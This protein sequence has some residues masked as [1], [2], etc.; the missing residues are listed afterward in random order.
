MAW[1]SPG[2]CTWCGTHG[3][4]GLPQGPSRRIR[5]QLAL[6]FGRVNHSAKS[7]THR[8]LPSRHRS[9][10]LFPSGDPHPP[11]QPHSN[12]CHSI[13]GPRSSLSTPASYRTLFPPPPSCPP[14]PG[15]F[16]SGSPRRTIGFDPQI[17]GC[18]RWN[19]LSLFTPL[20]MNGKP[21]TQF[22]QLATLILSHQQVHPVAAHLQLEIDIKDGRTVPSPRQSPGHM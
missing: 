13:H 6:G 20:T 7:P 14:L 3:R 16:V 11:C 19:W 9:N 4:L 21:P 2:M 12:I 5:L 18:T 1:A 15:S 17:F 8:S 10:P 22:R